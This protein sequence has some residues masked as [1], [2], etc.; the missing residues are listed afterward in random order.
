M[1]RITV[2]VTA[3]EGAWSDGRSSEGR[4]QRTQPCICRS[5]A[6]GQRTGST[7]GCRDPV[8]RIAEVL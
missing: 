1:A 8:P 2:E 7:Q 6:G 3:A 5:G 4:D